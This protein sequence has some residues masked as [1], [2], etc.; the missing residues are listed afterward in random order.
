MTPLIELAALTDRAW[1]VGGAVR[2]E[3]L[4]KRSTDFD[5]AVDGDAKGLARALGRAT[6]AS[7][8]ALSD[9]FGAWR[10]TAADRSW[11]V[12]MTPLTG[13]SLEAD[14]ANRDLTV[15][16][17][18][19]PLAGGALIDPFHGADDL[20]AGRLTMVSAGA[21]GADPLRVMRLARI[22]V[23][24][25]FVVE[26]GTLEAARRAAPRLADVPGERIYAE[27]RQIITGERPLEGLSGLESVGASA[28][29]LPELVA[30]H[31][32]EQSAYHHLD[33]YGHTL[34]TLSFAVALERDPA[35]VLGVPAQPVA[36]FLALPL[37]D[38]MTRGEVLRWAALL[39]DIAKPQTRAVTPEGR[40][41]FFGHDREGAEVN[42]AI[43]A[44]LRASEKVAAQ[45]AA[46]TRHHLRLGFLVHERPLSARDVYDYLA[47][48]EPVSADVT[49]LSVA[50]RLATR[51]RHGERAIA[52]HLEL[53]REMWPS[54][55]DWQRHRPRAPL[56]GD[57]LAGA[58]GRPAGPWLAAAL[59]E[60]SAARYAG[61][62]D[63]SAAKAV[64]HATAWLEQNG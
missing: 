58:L 60:L 45:V 23:E 50:D 26:P 20:R 4:G 62:I 49:L 44:R 54:A 9:A 10:V 18:A 51:G 37:A 2:D 55:L 22:A 61:E 35:G 42:R 8:F 21:F 34:E 29:V 17:I 30:L 15:N 39:H 64:A 28:I 59:E 12:D 32:V 36:D 25:E 7:S 6:G 48:C 31:G 56:R 57:D 43:F 13:T 40:I 63:D 46:L 16:A 1:L 11:Q 3:L 19:R 14:L 41:T 52:A 24:L 33:V 38:E 53:A 5:L 27:L 47:A